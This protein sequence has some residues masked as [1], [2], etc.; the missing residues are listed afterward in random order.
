MLKDIGR[1]NSCN[2]MFIYR[3]NGSQVWSC[4]ILFF[5]FEIIDKSLLPMKYSDPISVWYNYLRK[6]IKVK[7]RMLNKFKL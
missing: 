6:Y 7:I 4:N 3:P 2:M 5:M 1:C